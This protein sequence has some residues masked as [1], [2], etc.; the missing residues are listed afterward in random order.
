MNILTV[1]GFQ[2]IANVTRY[3]SVKTI[4]GFIEGLEA[5]CIIRLQEFGGWLFKLLL[6]NYL[7]RVHYT[8]SLDWVP[9]PIF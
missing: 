1:E 8:L 3:L 6:A 5:Y 7:S 2:T 9:S 4:D